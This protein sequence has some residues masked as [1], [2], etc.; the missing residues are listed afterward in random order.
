[1]NTICYMTQFV[2]VFSIPDETSATLSRYFMRYVFIKFGLCHL[3]LIDD[4]TPF[5]GYF[6]AMS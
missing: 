3:V 2:V 4:V 5:K 6:F 1:M